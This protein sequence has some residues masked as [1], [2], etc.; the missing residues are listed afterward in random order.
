MTLKKI[1][2]LFI[3][4]AS[5]NACSSV[6]TSKKLDE[7]QYYNSAGFALIYTE[8]LYSQKIINKKINNEGLH[9]LHSFLKVN[10]PI[11][12]INPKNSKYVETKVYKKAKYPTIFNIVLSK[13]I[14]SILELDIDNPYVEIF[15]IKKNKTF[16]AKESNTFEEEKNVAEKAPVNEIQVDDLSESQ[17]ETVKKKTTETNFIIIINEFYY[18]ESANKLKTELLKNI[19]TSK[20]SIKKMNKNKYRL[21]AGPFKNFNALKTTYISLNTLGFENLSVYKE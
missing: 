10:T 8:D 3:L 16:V 6:Q 9:A 2:L 20:I 5:L 4:I 18:F 13:K 12:I 15:E 14:S 17:T 11:K 1:I 7:K 19:K 21:F